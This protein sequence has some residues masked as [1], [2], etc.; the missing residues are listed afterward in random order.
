MTNIASR[1]HGTLGF[2]HHAKR[3]NATKKPQKLQRAPQKAPPN[4]P[5]STRKA[6]R[7]TYEALGMASGG[8]SEDTIVSSDTPTDHK[9]TV[10]LAATLAKPAIW[11][12]KP[13]IWRSKPAIVSHT[14]SKQVEKGATRHNMRAICRSMDAIWRT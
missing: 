14:L 9:G 11:R 5:E 4:R 1:T 12:T 8:T 6:T 10:L 13:A 3:W 2:G 7:H